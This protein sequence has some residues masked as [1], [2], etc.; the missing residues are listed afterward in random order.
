MQKLLRTRLRDL[1]GFGAGTRD[2]SRKYKRGAGMPRLL[3]KKGKANLFLQ[4]GNP[5]VYSGAI[6]SVRGSPQDGDPVVLADWKDSAIGWGVY[7]SVSMFTCR[8]LQ[9]WLSNK[10][11]DMAC[12]LNGCHVKHHMPGFP[13]S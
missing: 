4:Y 7:N 9:V 5:M 6:E 2:A 11:R 3:V 13:C 10:P 1:C 8:V 12:A